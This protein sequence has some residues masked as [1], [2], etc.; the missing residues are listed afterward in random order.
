MYLI[1]VFYGTGEG[2]GFLKDNNALVFI[3]N[4]DNQRGHGAG[5]ASI[6]TFRVSRLY[7]MA[8]SFMLS[9]P[10]G[11]AQIMSSYYWEQNFVNG[12][13]KNDFVRK[14]PPIDI[15]IKLHISV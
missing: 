11:I 13:D 12:R 9:W 5:G 14:N 1:Y 6:L 10:Y 2:W 7:K 8:V 3:D 15:D 4:H